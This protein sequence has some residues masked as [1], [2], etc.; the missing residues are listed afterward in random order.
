MPE[1]CELCGYADSL[2]G[3]FLGDAEGVLAPGDS[4]KVELEH[5]FYNIGNYVD[6]TVM[7]LKWKQTAIENGSAISTETYILEM[8]SK[9]D[10][11]PSSGG[12]FNDKQFSISPDR[13]E[14]FD[15][16]YGKYGYY[17]KLFYTGYRQ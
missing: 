15:D 16:E 1:N 8:R 4:L 11:V 12:S 2:T 14:I 17:V 6:S 10:I 7:F 9:D 3:T 5:V 13:I